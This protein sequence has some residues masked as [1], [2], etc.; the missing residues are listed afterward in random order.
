MSNFRNL[1][2][3]AILG[4]RVQSY[5]KWSMKINHPEMIDGNG[6]SQVKS[7][8]SCMREVFIAELYFHF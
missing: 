3:D 1:K 8:R 4:K 6:N 2:N 5:S 7:L